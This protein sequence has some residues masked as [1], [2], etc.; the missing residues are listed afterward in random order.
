MARNYMKGKKPISETHPYIA[1]FR[2][3][4]RN[5]RSPDEVSAGSHEKAW[6]YC[7][8]CEQEDEVAIKDM[9][10]WDSCAFC[11]GRKAWEGNC[12]STTHPYIATSRWS[13]RNT[14]SPDE[15]T[16]GSGETAWFVCPDCKQHDEVTICHM[17]KE[18]SCAYCRGLKVWDGNCLAKFNP[19]IIPVWGDKNERSP[20]EYTRV[21][22]KRVWLR[23][24]NP[25]SGHPEFSRTVGN[26]NQ[27]GLGCPL[28]KIKSK[29]EK[30]CRTILE[31]FTGMNSMKVDPRLAPV[32]G[33]ELDI[34]FELLRIN[35]EYNGNQ[36]YAMHRRFHKTM[37]DFRGQIDRDNN[38]RDGCYKEDILNIEIP[39]FKNLGNFAE[40][41]AQVM[42]VIQDNYV[43]IMSR[44]LAYRLAEACTALHPVAPT[45]RNQPELQPTSLSPL[46]SEAVFA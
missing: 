17:C 16:A 45:P 35:F 4:R 28:C 18:N 3:S 21:S 46:L 5:N 6:F 8:K 36:H 29:G 19:D 12:I 33:N 38:R 23:C 44:V 43:W 25:T 2:W 1:T 13:D 22:Q 24:S 34:Y 26:I 20:Y 10:K 37:D 15:F 31:T 40:C 30:L 14:K 9:C 41:E 39:E 27:M 42:K 11:Y 7:S 32:I